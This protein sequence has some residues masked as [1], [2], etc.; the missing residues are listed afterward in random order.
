MMIIIKQSVSN[1]HVTRQSTVGPTAVNYLMSYNYAGG[2]PYK[3]VTLAFWS[4]LVEIVAGIC[5][6]GFLIQFVSGPVMSAFS[7]VV[8]ILVI[9]S[10]VKGFFGVTFKG[11]GFIKIWYG[12]FENI[13]TVQLYDMAVGFGCMG[14][15][16]F[17]RVSLKGNYKS[18]TQFQHFV[19]RN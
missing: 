9:T 13:K 11:R 15:L 2:T 3:A 7:T 12:L 18:F 16:Y 14:L 8:S 17:L 5:N 4:G 19:T 6:L 10:S 1:I